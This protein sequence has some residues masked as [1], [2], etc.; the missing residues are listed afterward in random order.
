[1]ARIRLENLPN[2]VIQE[3][4]LHLDIPD[5]LAVSRTC[6]RLRDL[7]RDIDL[8]KQ[9]RARRPS[10]LAS[11]LS[12]PRPTE[13]D[14]LSRN[15]LL[16]PIRLAHRFHRAAASLRLALV[17]SSLRRGLARRPELS[18][19][20]KRGVYP[21]TDARVSSVLAGRCHDLERAS[22]K[23]SISSM[24]K[25]RCRRAT[26]SIAMQ[27]S[28]PSVS[29]LVARFSNIQQ[30]ER[31]TRQARDAPSRAKVYRLRMFFER[32]TRQR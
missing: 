14:L 18:E 27:D 31:P 24:F 23:S 26:C 1:M 32:L 2:E 10:I 29:T 4:L 8:H 15:I 19:L 11:L 6:H 9:L 22:S 30:H 20:I 16:F 12:F 28:T 13:H 21:A 25:R 7:A 17:R 5:L 3:M